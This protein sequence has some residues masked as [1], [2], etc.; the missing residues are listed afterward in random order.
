MGGELKSGAARRTSGC[1]LK[2]AAP[3][4]PRAE[5]KCGEAR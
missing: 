4:E 3:S 1:E 5:V 2:S